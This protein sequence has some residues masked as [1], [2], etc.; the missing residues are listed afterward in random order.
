[1]YLI[2][3]GIDHQ[4][5][6]VQDSRIRV[7]V[8]KLNFTSTNETFYVWSEYFISDDLWPY[9]IDMRRNLIWASI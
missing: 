1:M 6:S 7:E 8:N 9:T 4:L 3:L 2:N 5:K